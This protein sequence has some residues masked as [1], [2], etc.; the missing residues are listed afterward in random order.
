MP[1]SPDEITRATMSALLVRW[2]SAWFLQ[3]EQIAIREAAAK[4]AD[5]FGEIISKCRETCKAL[6]YDREEKEKW[7]EALKLFGAEADQLYE[8][9]RSPEMPDWTFLPKDKENNEEEHKV[10]E[11]L[12][13]P[14]PSPSA[15]STERPPIREIAL[16]RL[17][18]AGEK[19]ALAADIRDFIKSN[20]PGD[21]HYKTVGM[22]LYRLLKDGLITRQGH[23]WFALPQSAEK[24]NPGGE[25]PGLKDL[26]G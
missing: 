12:T 5:E 25:T 18:L 1:D 17:A 7:R 19:G 10:A 22:T 16:S 6:G 2:Q 26:L 11:T 4:R 20:Y 13:S 15:Q 8:K 14:Q 21:I 3:K 23:T 9:T 24:A